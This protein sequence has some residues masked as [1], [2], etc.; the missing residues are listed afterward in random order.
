[1]SEKRQ[2]SGAEIE[3]GVIRCVACESAYDVV[4]RVPNLLVGLEDASTR[5]HYSDHWRRHRE[6][7]LEREGIA[8]GRRGETLAQDLFAGALKDAPPGGWFLDA[9]CGRGHLASAVARQHPELQ[10]VAFDLSSSVSAIAR[11]KAHLANL[12]V[13]RGDVSRPPFKERAFRRITSLGVLHH[14]ADTGEAFGAVARLTE[15]GGRL[16]VWIYPDPDENTGFR[17]H[18]KLLHFLRRATQATRLVSPGTIIRGTALAILPF[19][20]LATR[21]R[22]GSLLT[23]RVSVRDRYRQIVFVYT[24]ELDLRFMH[25]HT[26]REVLDWYRANGFEQYGTSNDGLYWG[27]RSASH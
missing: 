3:R 6:A 10:V 13:V 2:T 21:R 14:T 27:A 15:P 11:D 8:F 9:G 1:M 18:Y 25:T 24:D 22:A 12:H 16:V 4:D 23:E 19:A 17:G 26:R 7:T 20:M 5:D